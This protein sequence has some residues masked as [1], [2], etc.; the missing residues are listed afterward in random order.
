MEKTLKILIL[1]FIEK[2]SKEKTKAKN[3]IHFLKNLFFV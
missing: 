1:R 2:K 3:S